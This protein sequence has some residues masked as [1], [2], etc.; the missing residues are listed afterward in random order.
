MYSYDDGSIQVANLTNVKQPGLKAT[1]KFIDLN[2]KIAG[3]SQASVPSL[4]SQDVKTVLSTKAP[5]GISKTYFLELTL[6]RGASVVSRNVYWLSTKADSIDWNK[7][8]GEGFGATYNANGYADLTGL[9]SLGKATVQATSHTT[10]RDGHAVTTVTVRNVSGQKTPAFFT[11]AD[12][13]RGTLGGQPLSGDNQVLPIQWSDNDITLWPGQSQ[14]LTAT[15]RL[16][17]LKG[18]SPV[19]SLSGWNVASQTVSAR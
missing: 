19:V 9:Q 14:T 7:T 5:A 17:D 13:L 10:V 3:T 1:A 8:L 11:R 16:S 6:S 2:G 4:S 15:Y 12:V 18:A